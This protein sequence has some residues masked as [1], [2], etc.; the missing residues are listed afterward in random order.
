MDACE[1]LDAGALVLYFPSPQ[2]VTGE[3]VLELHVHGG[4]AVVKAVLRAIKRCNT[5]ISTSSASPA[6]TRAGAVAESPRIRYAEPGEFTKRAFLNDRLDLPQIEALG[7]TLTAETEVQRQ[8]AVRGT[9]D[10]LARRYEA[11]RMQLLSARGELEA[12]IDFSEDQQLDAPPARLVSGVRE[13]V[14]ALVR[15]VRLH[16]ANAARGELM[17]GGIGVALLGAPNAGKSSLLNCAI[18]REAAIVSSE[19]GTTR[20]VVDVGVDLG[21]W[22]CRFGDMAGL[23]SGR[24]AGDGSTTSKAGTEIQM[25][26]SGDILPS[27]TTA[28]V[29]GAVEQEGIR[30]AKAR[31]LESDV[32]IVVLSLEDVDGHGLPRIE[33]EPEVVEA[34]RDCLALDKWVLVVINKCD[35]LWLMQGRDHSGLDEAAYIEAARSYFG[36][37]VAA[38]DVFLISCLDADRSRSVAGVDANNIATNPDPDPGHLQRFLQGLIQTFR[39][40]AAP[41]TSEVDSQAGDDALGRD[42]DAAAVASATYYA[43]SLAV[44]HRQS[45]L[46]EA[47]SRHLADFLD[48]TQ[49]TTAGDVGLGLAVADDYDVDV[50]IDVVTAAEHLRFAADCL[51]QITGQEGSDVEDVLGVVFER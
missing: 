9:S 38:S 30:R 11:W 16:V 32:V 45:A 14:T 6:T 17:R 41:T 8:L 46:L 43:D 21:G 20:D 24:D 28:E 2:T 15:A 4:P 49:T 29:I 39:D 7:A 10:T 19:R 42:L 1:V 3:D 27:T 31:A 5:V 37:Q 12:L 26:K 18:G 33:A 44:T 35:K 22:F 34:A 51:A 40:M 47:C 48:Q 23:R 50:E 13:Q 25:P 36:G